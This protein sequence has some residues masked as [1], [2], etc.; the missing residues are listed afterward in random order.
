M[1]SSTSSIGLSST[2]LVEVD[3]SNWSPSDTMVISAVSSSSWSNA[4]D[5]DEK[6]EEQSKNETVSK[7][8]QSEDWL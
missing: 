5:L 8:I 7:S 3:S 1:S 2:I 6:V 4:L